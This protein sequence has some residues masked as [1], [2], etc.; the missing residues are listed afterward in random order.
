MASAFFRRVPV[1]LSTPCAFYHWVTLLDQSAVPVEP[2]ALEP[3]TSSKHFMQEKGTLFHL[4]C[5][6][7]TLRH[8]RY[9]VSV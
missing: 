3:Q 5:I 6:L 2:R 9:Y 1:A 7:A 4:K 8:D